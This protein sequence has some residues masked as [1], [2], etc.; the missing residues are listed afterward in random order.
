MHY[1]YIT[2]TFAL[3][4]WRHNTNHSNAGNL[5]ILL[6]FTNFDKI[7][8][9]FANFSFTNF[10]HRS[11]K[12]G[13]FIAFVCTDFYI[14]VHC[15]L[16]T[17]LGTYFRIKNIVCYVI[18]HIPASNGKCDKSM[19]LNSAFLLISVTRN[20][21]VIW[22]N[23]NFRITSLFVSFGSIFWITIIVHSIC[24]MFPWSPAEWFDI[25]KILI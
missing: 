19:Q 9:K 10:I 4:I 12:F 8:T 18:D 22:S 17:I 3:F 14:T 16:I 20:D 24:I 23:P 21:P 13:L 15:L 6:N 25:Q 5:E 1:I 11:Q 2:T 7:S